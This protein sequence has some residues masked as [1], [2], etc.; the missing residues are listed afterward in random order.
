MT[1]GDSISAVDRDLV[2]RLG[3]VL[4][5]V[6]V[7]TAAFSHLVGVYSQKFHDRTAPAKFI[8][9]PHRMSANEPVAFFAAR[10]ITLPPNRVYARLKVLGDPEYTLYVNGR[11][12]AGRQ[13]GEDRALDYFD[14]SEVMQTGRN[15]IVV[16][17]RA[18]KGA[19]A[20]LVA[21]DLAPERENWIVS[22]AQWKIYR[23]WDPLILLYDVAGAW[24]R[25]MIVGAPP[26]G[27][28]NFLDIAKREPA[29]SSTTTLAPKQT[30]E[31][32]GLMPTIRTQGGISIA[33]SERA[34]AK[35]FDFGFTKG[36]VRVSIDR[37]RGFSR[38]VHVR[39]ANHR[40]ELGLLE[41]NPRAI[42]FAP[43]ETEVTTPEEHTFRYAMAFGRDVEV[44]VL[45]Q[46]IPR[47]DAGS[48]R[49]LAAR[50]AK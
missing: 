8:W 14:L 19:G 3:V 39:F 1:A 2:K 20:L 32:V 25:P 30:F 48:L 26:I 27:R 6:F 29:A 38:L 36:R 43:G 7:F 10:E 23:R 18:P 5:F 40:N 13:V 35:A 22:D 21:L 47:A 17:V 24:E 9:A 15:R 28:W 45:S 31:L 4:A 46:F 12:I 34:R 33:G 41:L 37:P 49:A 16:A 50:T 42:V 11:E 44:V